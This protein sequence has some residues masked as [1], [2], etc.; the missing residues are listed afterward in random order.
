MSNKERTLEAAKGLL[1]ALSEVDHNHGP[2]AAMQV[3][4]KEI[5]AYLEFERKPCT[6]QT[7]TST[8]SD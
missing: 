6:S 2:K 4:M 8:L 5:K 3:S 7:P 1:D